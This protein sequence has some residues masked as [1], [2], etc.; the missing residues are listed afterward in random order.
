MNDILT[1]VDFPV[2]QGALYLFKGKFKVIGDE[3]HDGINVI[4]TVKCSEG[5]F[6]YTSIRFGGFEYHSENDGKMIG[7]KFFGGEWF[8]INGGD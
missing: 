4:K 8:E 3:I 6:S 2:K 7:P 1:K 5:Y